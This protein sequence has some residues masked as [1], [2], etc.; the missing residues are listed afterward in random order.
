MGQSLVNNGNA[1]SL[2]YSSILQ[3]EKSKD[4]KRKRKQDD[5]DSED[6]PMKAPLSGKERAA[7]ARDRK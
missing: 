2:N 5:K 1:T 4:K 7:R 6:K 3:K